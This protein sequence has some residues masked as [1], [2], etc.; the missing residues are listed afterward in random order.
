MASP[1]RRMF[2]DESPLV[3]QS[4]DGKGRIVEV[5][6]I[7]MKHNVMKGFSPD[8]LRL[9][10][11]ELGPTFVKLGQLLASRSEMIPEAHRAELAKLHANCTPVSYER[12]VESIQRSFGREAFANIFASIDPEPLGSASIAQVHRATLSNGDVVAVKVRRPGVVEAIESDI[13]MLRSL[14]KRTRMISKGSQMMNPEEVIEELW[15]MFSAE[16]D[17]VNE[18]QNLAEFH[19]IAAT[20]RGIT[21]PEPYIE[22]CR[23]DV[24]VMEFVEGVPFTKAPDSARTEE[25]AELVLAAYLEHVLD[26]G[27]FH[28]DPHPG[29][30]FAT[31]GEVAFL[32]MGCMGRMSERERVKFE[33]IMRAAADKNPVALKDTLMAIATSNSDGMDHPGILADLDILVEEYCSFGT[34]VQLSQFFT[35]MIALTRKHSVSLPASLLDVAKGLVTLDVTISQAIGPVKAMDV[36]A[37]YLQERMTTQD[38][39]KETASEILLATKAATQGLLMAS[40]YSGDAMRMLS[41]GQ[42]KFNMEISHYDELLRKASRIL[43]RVAYALVIAGLLVSASLAQ[44]SA[45][46]PELFGTTQFG[47]IEYVVA[48]VLIIGMDM[49]IFTT[50]RTP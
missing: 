39:L 49:D 31:G 19:S 26:Y 24:L 14:V 18:A 27:F 45:G 41:R 50:R 25:T 46:S 42:L 6:R 36:V 40:R 13:Q 23:E 43:N 11:E 35:D 37:R 7:A 33:S 20:E 32:D 3:S 17:L 30:V 44:P 8:D 2:R 4:A 16:T 38:Q 21:S 47:F 29:N 22:L 10:L 12:I 1:I 34:E 15:N 28:A 9:C 48:F 5:L